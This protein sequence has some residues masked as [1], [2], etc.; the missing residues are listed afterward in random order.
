MESE[1][2]THHVIK[3]SVRDTGIGIPHS[4][5]SKLFSRFSQAREL[6][7]PITRPTLIRRLLLHAP[8]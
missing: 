3:I 4:A 1:T 5:Q 2:A 6:L 8:V 7:E